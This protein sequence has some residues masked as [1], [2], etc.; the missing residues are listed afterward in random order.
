MAQVKYAGEAA[1]GRIAD[2][3][4]KKLTFAS[5]MPVSP[6]TNTLV[7][8][9][10][11]TTGSFVQ[12]GIYQYDGTNW[13]LINSVTVELTQAEYDALPQA[14]KENGTIY[15]ITDAVAPSSIVE[16]YYNTT[17]GKFYKE[18]TYTTEITGGIGVIYISLD[19][20]MEYRYD[21]DNSE[22]VQIAGSGSGSA[23]QYVNSLPVTGIQDIIYGIISYTNHSDTISADF[24][25]NNDLFEKTTSGDDYTYT[26][27]SGKEI[28]A[29][30]DGTI[31]LGFT[32]LTY[33]NT[34]GDWTLVFSNGTD[35]TLA[36]ADTFYYREKNRNY[37]AG[38]ATEQTVTPFASG[39]G[40][41]GSQTYIPGEGIDITNNIISVSPA[42]T[43]T[44]GGIKVDDDT[45]K[46]DANGEISG[47][48]EGGYGIKVT[49]NEIATK[50]FVGTKAEWDNLTS[51]QKAKFDTVSITD[52]YSTL[53]NTPGHEIL[54]PSGT[55]LPQREQLKFVGATVADDST[56]GITVVTPI[57]YTA[58][59]KIDITNYEVSCDET[60]KGTFIGTQAEWDALNTTDKAKYEVVNI[61]D[62]LMTGSTVVD[63]VQINNMNAV[64]SNAVAEFKNILANQKSATATVDFGNL[65]YLDTDL[66][67]SDAIFGIITGFALTGG[68]G[69]V[70]ITCCDFKNSNSKIFVRCVKTGT[71]SQSVYITV[72]YI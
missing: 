32:S 7:L 14:I 12:G 63:V 34:S 52:D 45:I 58:G 36:A 29:S 49:G 11:T 70:A 59:D 30:D 31:Y 2:Y 72:K 3:V 62:D 55:A 60:V 26:A 71:V 50:T 61:T 56:N 64:T 47:N 44:L 18:N 25:D 69:N 41:G 1:V 37:Y 16:G 57:E 27:V 43:S 38:N 66:P 24:L 23:I 42:T 19:T 53:N 13:K 54:D 51:T 17:D 21:V 65:T 4:N 8:Y 15:F 5:S 20:N 35:V 33:D 10:G 28:E 6:N 40:G 22:F 68:N 46:V 48:Y 39:S 9:T 67:V